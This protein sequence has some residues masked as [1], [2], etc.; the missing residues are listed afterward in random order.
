MPDNN[1]N[2]KPFIAHDQNIPEFTFKAVFLGVVLAIVLGAANTYLGLYAGMTVSASIPA[3]V[4]SMAIL[5][6]ILKRGTILEN[7]IVQTIA[8]AGQS[9]AAGLIF[10]IP[11]LIIVGAWTDF[12]F[13]PTA[14]MGIAGVL[15]GVV[16]MIPLRKV[17]IIEEKELTYPE[18]VAC[19][20]VLIVGEKGG[21]RF[22]ET[23]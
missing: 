15:L 7:N 13:W 14:L 20:E 16:F 8:S 10:T 11:A 2:F 19:A 3:A 4:I 9:V 23:G 21:A 22:M 1:E 18:G 12:H 6:G 17:L 5:R